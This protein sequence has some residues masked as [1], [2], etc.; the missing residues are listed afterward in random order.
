MVRLMKASSQ[1]N[2]TPLLKISSGV[3]VLCKAATLLT[4]A[5]TDWKMPPR[6]LI[7]LSALITATHRC[8]AWLTTFA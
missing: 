6:N 2:L 5:V 3:L 4:A 1:K 7:A 8:F